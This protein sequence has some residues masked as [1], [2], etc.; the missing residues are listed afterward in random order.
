MLTNFRSHCYSGQEPG[1][2]RKGLKSQE[3]GKLYFRPQTVISPFLILFKNF[4]PVCRILKGWLLRSSASHSILSHQYAVLQS[5]AKCMHTERSIYCRG[6]HVRDFWKKC[7]KIELGQH[8]GTW[9]QEAELLPR[10]SSVLW[11]LMHPHKDTAKTLVRVGAS[12]FGVPESW[13]GS[14]STSNP[15]CHKIYKIS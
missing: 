13:P 12:Q 9:Q 3:I 2:R 11:L 8:Q 6:R 4:L 15:T 7:L 10:V 5:Q 1:K 14:L